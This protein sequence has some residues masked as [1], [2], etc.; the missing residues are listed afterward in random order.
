MTKPP[1]TRQLEKSYKLQHLGS[2]RCSPD[3][4]AKAQPP[5][6][7][8]EAFRMATVLPDTLKSPTT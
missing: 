5:L 4:A 3:P 6:P 1:R 2:R 8:A 7:P